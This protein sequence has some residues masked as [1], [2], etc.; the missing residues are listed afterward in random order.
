MIAQYKELAGLWSFS[1]I[2][3]FS[4]QTGIMH[5]TSVDGKGILSA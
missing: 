2:F 5:L 1:G 3:E 4:N